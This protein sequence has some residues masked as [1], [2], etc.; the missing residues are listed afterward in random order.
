AT[1]AVTGRHSNQ[2]NYRI[3]I[4]KNVVSFSWLQNY[5]FFCYLQIILKKMPPNTGRRSLSNLF[6][7]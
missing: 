1:S 6:F 5:N 4:L 2:L 3:I 7:L